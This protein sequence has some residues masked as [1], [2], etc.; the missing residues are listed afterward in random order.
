MGCVVICLRYRNDALS[1]TFVDMASQPTF[2]AALGVH[3]AP[4]LVAV[5]T[6]RRPG[7]ATYAAALESV[8]LLDSGSTFLDALL[9]G[10][11]RF[12]RFPEQQLPEL[13]QSWDAPLGARA[14]GECKD[15]AAAD[16]SCGSSGL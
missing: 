16:D 8:R 15:D 13:S 4:G 1:F 14:S 3:A 12:T 11:L 5:K 7:F 9:G 6:G 10:D 2:A